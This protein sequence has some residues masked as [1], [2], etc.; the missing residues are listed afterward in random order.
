MY[1]GGLFLFVGMCLS[2]GS[3]WDFF[4]FLLIFW[5]LSRKCNQHS[6][7]SGNLAQQWYIAAMKY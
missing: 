3:W 1:M 2:L 4:V 6:C 7:G 5:L